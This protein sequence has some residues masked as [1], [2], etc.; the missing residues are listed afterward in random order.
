MYEKLKSE[1]KQ[2]IEL[3]ESLPEK[4]RDK[5]FELLVSRFLSA[6][7]TGDKDL[8]PKKPGSVPPGKPGHEFT[9]PAK[10]RAFIKRYAITDEQLRSIVMLD[11]GDVHFIHEPR[12][13]K[14]ATGQIQWALLLGF[15]SALLGSDM[16]VDPEAVRSI[17]IEKGFYDK[18]NFAAHFKTP[19]N[20]ALFNG[21]LKPQ[22][23]LRKLT[24]KGEEKLAE[25]LKELAT[26]GAA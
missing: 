1:L 26:R 18:A 6:Q 2:I 16:T 8:D 12:N 25:I 24:P 4:Y 21:L 7:V 10:V 11:A 5:S 9:V 22:G 14:N 19:A 17:C 3:V 13:V 15:K 20:K 23:E